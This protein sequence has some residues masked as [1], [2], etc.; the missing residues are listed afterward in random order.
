MVK[1]P[2]QK[3]PLALT[4]GERQLMFHRGCSRNHTSSQIRGKSQK[5]TTITSKEANHGK[6]GHGLR[7]PGQ[8]FH[9]DLNQFQATPRT[10]RWWPKVI[11][12]CAI[13]G[14][15]Y[16]AAIGA[17]IS[18]TAGAADVIGI[19]AAVMAVL[20]GVPGARFGRFFG[21]VNRLR[22]GRWFLGIIA[23]MGGAILGGL[24]GIVVVM[25]LVAVLWAITGWFVTQA[26]LRGF[27]KR[28]LGGIVGVVVGA[29]FGATVLALQR[30]QAAAL[31]G[32]AW[33]I[34]I[35]VVV[36]PLPLLLFVKM[37]DSLARQRHPESKI[38][39]TSVI[40]VPNDEIEGPRS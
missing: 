38:I 18:T 20:C 36:G 15:V 26:I 11:A 17:T 34:G 5:T 3:V 6:R 25:P 14:G 21:M 1:K 33:G 7:M 8:E 31:V 4:E 27:F 28:L 9:Y 32:I 13:F 37:L 2:D 24:L 29:C 10:G 40:D 39:D 35:G 23:A 22:F 30:D 16:G 19:A 12:I